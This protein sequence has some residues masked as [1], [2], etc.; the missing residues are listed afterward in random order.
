MRKP[1]LGSAPLRAPFR[2]RFGLSFA[3]LHLSDELLRA[4]NDSGY[5][6]PTPI[7]RQAIPTILMGRDIIGVAQTG[8]GKTASF[9]L[10]MIDILAE[11]RGRA[12]M[13]RSLILA[14]TRELAAQVAENFEKYG[15]Y[16][17]LTMALLIGGVSFGD[18]DR[19]LEKGVDVL[20]ATPGRLMDQFE[21]GKILMSGV[22]ILVIDE[23]DRMLDMGFIPDVEKIC[24]KIN[25]NRQTLLFSATMPP[26]IKKLADR[27][28][29]DPKI[30]EVARPAST[31]LSIAQFQVP[32]TV[33]G[34]R[35]TLR[36]LLRAPDVTT[37][38]IFCNR[39]RDVKTLAEALQQSGFRAGQIHGD[40]EQ[41]D[42][43]ATL[44]KFK[45]DEI[46]I[47]VCSDVAAR[48]LDIKGVSHVFNY[49]VSYNADDYV[50]RVGRTGR[51]GKTGIA[52]TLVTDEDS[53]AIADIEKLIGQKIPRYGVATA[54]AAPEE[55][56]AP[57][58]AEAPAAPVAPASD[59]RRR[60]G[61]KPKEPVAETA[62][63]P[64]AVPEPV[65]VDPE[66]KPA[67]TPA[68][69]PRAERAPRPQRAEPARAERPRRDDRRDHRSEGRDRGDEPVGPGF[70]T[71]DM[72][73]AFMTV[74]ARI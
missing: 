63:Q 19:A 38:M 41:A 70:G 45:A 49:D 16:H 44:N 47:L 71:L 31:N 2:E 6:T 22:D 60:V 69:A 10:P 55:A 51:A 25:R 21:R 27:F 20:I 66:P 7:Q 24:E 37:A 56:P 53:E 48:G 57:Q 58:A 15:K 65:A 52:M 42:R 72:V 29:K 61:R 8:T 59:R 73:P 33:R 17:R 36:G 11:G 32:T 9:V 4:V 74:P 35:E 3:D 12:R 30:I 34:K 43:T 39:K 62:P 46:N 54:S 68:P 13:P 40:M 18:Q 64:E 28:M 14:P 23:A 26:P 67:P 50:H 5:T 1:H